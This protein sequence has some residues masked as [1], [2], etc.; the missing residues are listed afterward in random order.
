MTTIR[1]VLVLHNEHAAQT[2]QGLVAGIKKRHAN[3]CLCGLH[4]S[5]LGNILLSRMSQLNR[6]DISVVGMCLTMPLRLASHSNMVPSLH[7]GEF[8]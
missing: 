5:M 6:K 7:V 8:R 1:F 2:N 3:V 4:V